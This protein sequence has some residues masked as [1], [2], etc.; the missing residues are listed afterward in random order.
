[1]DRKSYKVSNKN[2]VFLICNIIEYILWFSVVYIFVNKAKNQNTDSQR[3]ILKSI[4]T[5]A[6]IASPE[7]FSDYEKGIEITIIAYKGFIS[8][9]PPIQSMDKNRTQAKRYDD[10][11]HQ[12]CQQHSKSEGKRRGVASRDMN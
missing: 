5:L 10:L 1:M 3:V 2:S 12:V 9:L 6:N 4:A 11:S 8:L 7:D